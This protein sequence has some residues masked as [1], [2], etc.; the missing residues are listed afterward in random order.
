[1]TRILSGVFDWAGSIIGIG[2]RYFV[3]LQASVVCVSTSASGLQR[4]SRRIGPVAVRLRLVFSLVLGLANNALSVLCERAKARSPH[5][6]AL[7][8]EVGREGTSDLLSRSIL[9]DLV[10]SDRGVGSALCGL[11][12]VQR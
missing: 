1:M 2:N 6:H 3:I 12:F 5:L 11:L 4:L 10:T 9:A 7:Q 8:A